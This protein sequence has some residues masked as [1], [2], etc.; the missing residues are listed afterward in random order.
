[1]SLNLALL[2]FF[3]TIILLLFLS[4]TRFVLSTLRPAGFPPG[5]PTIPGLGNIHQLPWSKAFLTFES[6]SKQYGSILGLKFGSVN[7]VVLHRAEQVRELF[8][9][10][11]AH[12][13]ARPKMAIPCDYVFPGEWEHYPGFMNI[14][15]QRRQRRSSKHHLGPSGLAEFA[16][17]QRAMAV[18]LLHSLLLLPEGDSSGF[19]KHFQHWTLG[20][21]LGMICGQRIEDLGEGWAEKYHHTQEK[22]LELVE[23]GGVAPP[24]D[25]FP[26]LA[27]VPS[28]LAKWKQKAA[29]VR[30]GVNETYNAMFVH[31]QQ[32]QDNE[33]FVSRWE[34]MMARLLRERDES[35][36]DIENPEQKEPH[37]SDRDIALIGG[38]VLDGASHST[39]AT[40][41]YFVQALAAH[42]DI[43]RR[44]QAEIDSYF[45]GKESAMLEPIDTS[46]LPYLRACIME[47]IRWRS[48]TPQAVP[49]E[50]TADGNVFGY[51]IPK[52]TM[53][54]I[55]V[56]AIHHD[57]EEYD[58]P[59]EFDPERFIRNPLGMK[60][61][62]ELKKG[63]IDSSFSWRKPLYSFGAGRRS[64][65]GEQFA[66]SSILVTFALLLWAY[67]IVPEGEMDIS[68]ETG[69]H[70]G[71]AVSPNPFRVRFV[72]RNEEV[73]RELME[74]YQKA[75]E[76]LIGHLL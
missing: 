4:I 23:P 34:P 53:V 25:I 19:Q 35:A 37:F 76:L 40:A 32:G 38:G 43:Q 13:A 59:N 14:E 58:R 27:W 65:P 20:M 31:V 33:T 74:Q 11:G 24:I 64:C 2:S 48:I 47:L 22:L 36:A 68:V 62:Q 12:Y 44:V 9:K 49:R 28:S 50:C 51:R 5:P 15:F 41:L 1:M 17:I 39:L 18:R 42:T 72:V 61:D 75:D 10:R 52:G 45:K 26:F 55:N 3:L 7:V 71:A 16:P 56:W 66:M 70:E 46:L 73:R 57:P 29:A 60:C 30:Q 21:A 54:M 69:M 8:E 6:W 63:E 67:D